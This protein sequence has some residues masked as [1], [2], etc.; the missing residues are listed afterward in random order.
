MET[1][2]HILD[3]LVTKPT[4][5]GNLF[6]YILHQR[7]SK[8]KVAFKKQFL[9][10][11]DASKKAE[12]Q[13]PSVESMKW[14]NGNK[15][16]YADI[17]A[18]DATRVVLSPIEGVIGSDYINA[19]LVELY[20]Y[21]FICTQAPLE[22]TIPDF[23]RMI[24]EQKTKVIVMTTREFEKNTIKATCYW[25]KF[26]AIIYGGFIIALS[27]SKEIILNQLTKRVFK[28]Q[29]IGSDEIREVTQFQYTA[30]PD[31]G[32]P[33]STTSFIRLNDEIDLISSSEDVSQPP[34]VVHCSA[35]IGRTGV[36]VA[37]RVM[38]NLLR[39]MLNAQLLTSSDTSCF[40]LKAIT[41]KMRKQRMEMIQTLEQFKFCYLA[42]L[43]EYTALLQKLRI[44]FQGE[45]FEDVANEL[46]DLECLEQNSNLEQLFA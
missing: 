34:I 29:L 41:L 37:F 15:N 36:L 14:Y 24:W 3:S 11:V 19:N 26:G 5:T 44:Q 4:E 40:D 45:G 22:S 27:D 8:S 30:W 35:G 20:S 31:M 43:K 39:K 32:I 21:K 16:R 17:Q 23:W 33:S 13:L 28:V 42:L 46:V 25:P 12:F 38:R 10:L 2:D 6:A 9:S 1:A 7:Q 18:S